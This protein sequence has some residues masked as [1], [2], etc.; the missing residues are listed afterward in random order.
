[1][2]FDEMIQQIAEELTVKEEQVLTTVELLDDDKTIPFIS[3]YRKEQTGALNEIQIRSI[4]EKIDY[5][6]RLQTRREEVLSTIEEQG[7]LTEDLRVS[8]NKAETFQ[9]VEDLYLPYKRRK[10]TRADKAR[11]AGL[12]PLYEWLVQTKVG[13][14]DYIA[15]FINEEKGVLT[16]EEG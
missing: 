6:R 9:A 14:D 3:R 15:S 8:L 2:T 1:M 13:D 5:L 11:E 12:E 10:K 4:A 7:K 16:S